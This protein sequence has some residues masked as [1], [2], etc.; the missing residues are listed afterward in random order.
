MPART[1]TQSR[2]VRKISCRSTDAATVTCAA[3][4]VAARAAA[5]RCGVRTKDHWISSQQ[6]LVT[7]APPRRSMGVHS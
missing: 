5:E 6:G 1:D 2:L 7:R 4:C 3:T